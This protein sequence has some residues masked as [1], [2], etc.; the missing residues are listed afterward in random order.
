LRAN[1]L[2]PHLPAIAAWACVLPVAA[3]AAVRTADPE[4]GF[5]WVALI[6][7][8][9][10]AAAV[11][12]LPVVIALL[13]RRW[14]AVAVAVTAMALLGAAVVPRTFAGQPAPAADGVTLR[15]LSANL[16]RG[17]ADAEAV[18]ELVRTERVDALSVQEL[19]TSAAGRLS[20]AGIRG[21]LPHRLLALAPS[22]SGGGL[23]ANLPLRPRQPRPLGVGDTRMPRGAA[24]PPGAARVDLVVVHPNPPT[25]SEEAERWQA[26]LADLP[27]P[28][29]E[30]A[31]RILAG[32]FNGTLDHAQLRE[33]L[34]AGYVDAAD[35]VGAGLEGTWNARRV[36][37][38]PLAIDHVLVD[39]RIHVESVEVHRLPGS[40]HNAVL[41]ELTLPVPEP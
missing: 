9:P 37:P 28:D 4:L 27:R 1:S 39:P 11:S 26:I 36:I 35:A 8:T 6:A 33:L 29:E 20:A 24:K 16:M 10:Y 17:R 38:P 22:S 31:L 25:G 15:V 13:L 40:D 19:T 32:D 34:D 21:L 18:V 12:V 30:G 14:V 3:W 41:A 23:Y 5:P 7:Y 2:R